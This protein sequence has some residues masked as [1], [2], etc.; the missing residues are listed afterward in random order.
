MYYIGSCKFQQRFIQFIENLKTINEN[1][2]IIFI[3]IFFNF[4]LKPI[5]VAFFNAHPY[6][7]HRYK[8]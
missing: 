1:Y 5:P 7:Q 8:L 6:F 2:L 3:P 4:N